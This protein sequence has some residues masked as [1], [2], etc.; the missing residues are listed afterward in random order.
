MRYGMKRAQN[1]M[2]ACHECKQ[3]KRRKEF[4]SYEFHKQEVK[5]AYLWKKK[6]NLESFD[7]SCILSNLCQKSNIILDEY[8][9]LHGVPKTFLNRFQD[10]CDSESAAEFSEELLCCEDSEK[11]IFLL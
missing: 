5:D 1:V 8:I 6:H 4:H 9:R 7:L 3:E 10:L 2:F 11:Q